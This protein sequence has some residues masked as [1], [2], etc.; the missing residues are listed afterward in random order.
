MRPLLV[1]NVVGLTPALLPHTPRI[2]ALGRDGF[3]AP[4]G[5]VLPAVTCSAQATLLTGRLPREHGI[6]ANGWYFRDLSE[7]WLWRQS[8]RLVGCED[9]K[10]W[11]AGRRRFG[12]D[13]TTAKMFWW[14]NMYAQVDWSVTP[15]P[16]YP[17]DGRKLPS[18]YTEPPALKDT[19]Q[20]ALGTFPLFNFWGPTAD[21]RSSAWIARATRSVMEA[22]RPAL[23][24]CYLPHL[25]YDL[26][27]F[28]PDGP[29]AKRACAEIDTVAGDLIDWA[30]GA[31]YTVVVL[32]EYG[33][34]P[35]TDA[36]HIN[37]VLRE[38]GLLRAQVVDT[39]WEL[40]D[41]GASDAFAVADHQIAHVYVRNPARVSA[42]KTLLEAVDGI[43]RVLDRAAQAAYGIDHERAGELVCIAAPERWFSYYYWLD[44]QRMPD[45]ARTVDIHRK[46]GYDPA[47]LL[48]DREIV[49]PKVRIGATLLKKIMGFRYYMNVIGLDARV[50]RGTHGR[51]PA[52]D[53]AG[54]VFLCSDPRPARD[55][56]AMTE[57]RDLL[58]ELMAK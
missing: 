14:Y 52:H 16:V 18:I 48:L 29:E 1:L 5:T 57:V 11:N 3:T 4:L 24:L 31:G 27:R 51:L 22:R 46:P 21:I 44:P 12:A 20:G 55:R 39:G 25:D 58:L 36:V 2:A 37:R 19:L 40:L 43:D 45:F 23:T 32:S 34:T 8:N 49:L 6:V 35:C 33:I 30:R 10:I 41:A 42:V 47:E 56:L 50:V 38:A 26:Q 9:D 7:I 28:G 53:D 15:R 54:P 13:F 17:A